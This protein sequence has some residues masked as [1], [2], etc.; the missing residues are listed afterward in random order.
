MDRYC[1][2][3]TFSG[4]GEAGQRAIGASHV[5]VVGLGALGGTI[6]MHLVRAGVG[7]L[8][9]CEH[10][11]IDD[12]NIQ[13]QLL[14][15]EG[16]VGEPKLATA[17]RA[18]GRMNS[19]VEIR[20]F[21]E[22][23]DED[24]AGRILGDA[25]IVVDGTD[26]MGPRYVMNELCVTRGIPFIYGGVLGGYGMTLSVVPDETPC[27]A[28]V[29]PPSEKMDH[30]PSCADVGIVNTVPAILG[31]MQATEALKMLVGAPYSK[32]LIIYD[33]W[34]QTFD[35]VPVKKRPDCPVCGSR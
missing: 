1:R 21:D 22:F 25:D 5:A 19:S 30:L 17:V 32:D 28:C 23:L 16:D 27:L 7:T 8:T 33:V 35:K 15:T 6:S 13:R 9:V 10:D 18:L 3:V 24:N 20:P 11:T 4:I 12:H 14:Y 26:R 29:F 34:E 2:N 31:S